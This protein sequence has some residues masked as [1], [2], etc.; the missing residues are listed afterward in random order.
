MSMLREFDDVVR[1]KI[2]SAITSC[3]DSIMNSNNWLDSHTLTSK[4]VHT[5]IDDTFKYFNDS[6]YEELKREDD[7]KSSNKETSSYDDYAFVNKH[8]VYWTMVTLA[9]Y[10][11]EHPD[12]IMMNRC[13]RYI[14]GNLNYNA[15]KYLD[16]IEEGKNSITIRATIMS[17]LQHIRIDQP[18]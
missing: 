15:E 9:G 8:T 16:F 4:E 13:M 17:I 7:H 5:I 11:S 10:V 3:I 6:L 12:I 2:I 14:G 18:E 1:S